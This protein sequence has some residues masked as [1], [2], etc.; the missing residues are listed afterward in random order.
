MDVPGNCGP[1]GNSTRLHPA[2]TPRQERGRHTR[3]RLADAGTRAGDIRTPIWAS[4][5][6][7]WRRHTALR[8]V[9]TL[10]G[11]VLRVGA[12]NLVSDF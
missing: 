2:T 3:E 12:T 9:W 8:S 1:G 4:L 5:R 11:H 7:S 10:S 6:V